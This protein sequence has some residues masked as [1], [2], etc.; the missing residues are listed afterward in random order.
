MRALKLATVSQFNR[1]E[2]E[3]QVKLCDNIELLQKKIKFYKDLQ[4][5]SSKLFW[6]H[7]VSTLKQKEV[8][9][10]DNSIDKKKKE[11]C[12][13]EK[14]EYKI[15]AS[16]RFLQN[17]NNNKHVILKSKNKIYVVDKRGD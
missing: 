10:N 9:K 5:S 16:K 7:S 6:D 11:G 1:F 2:S 14:E 17:A 4:S 13:K 3:S 12:E 15:I 8:D